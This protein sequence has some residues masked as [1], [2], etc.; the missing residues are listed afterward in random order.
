[1]KRGGSSGVRTSCFPPDYEHGLRKD[2]ITFVQVLRDAGYRA[3]FAGKWHLGDEGN[4]PE[5]FGFEVNVGGFRVGSPP[6]GY[7]SPYNNP[8]LEDGPPG[9]SLPIR[10]GMETANWIEE[11][12][13]EPFVAYLSFYS[14]HG[15]I[16]TSSDRWAKYREKERAR[17]HK[18]EYDLMP[19]FKRQHAEYLDPE[20]KPN[21]DWWQSQVVVD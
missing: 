6:G 11:H 21:D 15:P 20:W 9:E 10:L 13:D 18:M 17:L 7:F 14:V 5:Q 1:M 4:H 2:E 3:F 16:Q 19:E 8:Y 12:K